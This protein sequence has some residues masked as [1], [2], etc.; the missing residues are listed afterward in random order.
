MPRLS[1]RLAA[2]GLLAILIV[3]V[4]APARAEAR[5]DGGGQPAA[6]CR[7]R[8]P[9][10]R[11]RQ[12]RCQLAPSGRAH[13]YGP[14]AP[15]ASAACPPPTLMHLR[16]LVSRSTLHV[17]PL[18]EEAEAAGEEPEAP[19]VPA[20]GCSFTFASGPVAFDHCFT[21]AGVGTGFTIGWWVRGGQ[22]SGGSGARPGRLPRC[23]ATQPPRTRPP[24]ART[25]LGIAPTQRVR[26]GLNASN[27]GYGY[28][29][30]GY[31]GEE[32]EENAM[33]GGTAFALLACDECLTGAER[34]QAS[35]AVA[36]VLGGG[37][38]AG[39]WQACWAVAGGLGGARVAA[40]RGL[41]PWRRRRL[42][43]QAPNRC[44]RRCRNPVASP[45]R[46]APACASS[47]WRAPPVVT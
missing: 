22:A 2:A 7:R 34:W 39:R 30:L 21:A 36:G 27:S 44:R 33:I 19:P 41:L 45:L 35:W 29:A 8:T 23:H 28:V 18:Q 16:T 25:L 10:A 12:L 32:D 5:G 15:A 37:R 38:G 31:P 24:P 1:G 40:G 47:E 46:Q 26:W 42:L 3:T 20:P 4:A 6:G 9:L 17:R 11:R 13:A 14:S 43:A